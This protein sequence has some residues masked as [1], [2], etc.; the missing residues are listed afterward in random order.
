M[1]K[2][3]KILSLVAAGVLTLGSAAGFAGCGGPKAPEG[4][5]GRGTTLYVQLIN[6]TVEADK[7]YERLATVYNE[8]QGAEDDKIGRASCR[9]IV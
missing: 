7:A 4:N 8:T 1:M 2:K 9:E 6:Y 3:A 5:L